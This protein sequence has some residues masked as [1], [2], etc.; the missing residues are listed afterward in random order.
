[1]CWAPHQG[2]C[3]C[4]L[5]AFYIGRCLVLL[6]AERPACIHITQPM[7]TATTGST[8]LTSVIDILRVLP[9]MQTQLGTVVSHT[10]TIPRV[11]LPLT[12][13]PLA[14]PIQRGVRKTT[15][16]AAHRRAAAVCHAVP[17]Q[18]VSSS[19]LPAA[20]HAA[21]GLQHSLRPVIPFAAT[22]LG[23]RY[24]PSSGSMCMHDTRPPLDRRIIQNTPACS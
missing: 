21:A 4:T 15:P 16:A 10:E 20:I 2:W 13:S 7:L 23:H 14:G 12:H 19:R 17:K 24:A 9:I 8:V 11:S 22:P 5:Y 6:R 3:L 1:M 18:A